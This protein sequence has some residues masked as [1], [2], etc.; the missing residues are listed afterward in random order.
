MKQVK[1]LFAAAVLLGAALSC[2]A[3]EPAA[4]TTAAGNAPNTL[5]VYFSCTNT[6]KGRAEAL[7]ARLGA[8]IYRIVPEV[9]YTAA[10]LDYTT[11]CRANREQKDA[12][13]RPKISG[14]AVQL[15][16]YD[17]VYIGYPIWW[18]QAPKIIYT[19]LESHDFAGKTVIPFCTSGG[20]GMGSS[21]TNLRR[22]APQAVW[23]AG[24]L[25]RSGSDI[26][27]LAAMK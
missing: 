12:S 27:A 3:G 9:P 24:R 26:D 8:D 11:D 19:F 20:S 10:D 6:T 23:K 1:I 7:Q 5:V 22:F 4:G 14:S 13:A 16:Q 15:E 18:G 17:V 21:G 25:V 2:A